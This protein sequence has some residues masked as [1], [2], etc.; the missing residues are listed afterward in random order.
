[1]ITYKWIIPA[2]DCAIEKNG[3]N[4]VVESI[5]WRYEGTDENNNTESIFGLQVVGEPNNELFTE[6]S[7][8][9]LEIVSGWLEALIDVEEM[10]TNISERIAAKITPTKIML[11]LPNGLNE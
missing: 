9:T 5:H 10:K 6:Y 7:G 11:P 4:N 1:M 3:L 8:L 2:L